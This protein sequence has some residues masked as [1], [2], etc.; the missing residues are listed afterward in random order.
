MFLR[1]L[2]SKMGSERDCE[3][4]K[5]TSPSAVPPPAC[6]VPP[7]PPRA[8]ALPP[9]PPRASALPPVPPRASALPPVPPRASALPPVPPRASALPPVP[10]RASAVPPVPPRASAVSPV[11]PR[12]SAAPSPRAQSVEMLTDPDGQTAETGRLSSHPQKPANITRAMRRAFYKLLDIPQIKHLFELDG[13]RRVSDKYLLAL[14]LIYFHRAGLSIEEFTV[15]NFFAALYLAN[16]ME[17]DVDT[18]T[19][20]FLFGAEFFVNRKEFDD[21]V[22]SLYRRLNYSAWVSPEECRHV[23]RFQFH[24]AWRRQRMAYHGPAIM[25]KYRSDSEKKGM[26]PGRGYTCDRCERSRNQTCCILQ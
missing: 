22:W 24:W 8:S 19:C 25:E 21:V 2:I 13:C 9:V 15:Q 20:V 16:E 7:V 18:Y 11:P 17:E 4:D 6:P 14:V 12:A 3:R 5:T 26:H 23:M 1:N 10:P